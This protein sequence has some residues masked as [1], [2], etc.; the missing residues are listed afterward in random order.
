MILIFNINSQLSTICSDKCKLSLPLLKLLG[1][2]YAKI[3][4]YN[5]LKAVTET[6]TRY[7]GSSKKE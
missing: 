6:H 1:D 7:S 5:T 3:Q 4:Q 2:Q